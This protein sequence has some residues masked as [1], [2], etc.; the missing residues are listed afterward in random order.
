M[1]YQI[2]DHVLWYE[3]YTIYYNFPNT[4]W[5]KMVLVVYYTFY[6]A[7]PEK[8]TRPERCNLG[9]GEVPGL[10]RAAAAAT[11]WYCTDSGNEY[12]INRCN[13]CSYIWILR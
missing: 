4:F 10:V 3:I 13:C 6:N 8:W 11:A 2:Y 7:Q 12:L 9:I 5:V 1:V